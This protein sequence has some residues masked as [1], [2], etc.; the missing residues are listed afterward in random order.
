[1]T[2]QVSIND[3]RARY[4]VTNPA[5]QNVFD[6]DFPLSGVTSIQVFKSGVL[7]DAADYTVDLEAL[8]VT[9][10]VAAVQGV[11]VTLEGLRDLRRINGFPLRGG[12]ESSRI[13][14][15][16]NAVYQSLQEMRRD[17]DRTIIFNKAEADG[18]SNQLPVF[19]ANKALV[20]NPAGDGITLSEAN[21]G[22]LDAIIG[23]VTAARDA[24]VAAQGGAETAETG[25]E[26]AQAAAETARDL[27]QAAVG[28]VRVSGDDL[29]ADNLEAKL[30]AGDGI[31]LSTQNSGGNETRRIDLDIGGLDPLAVP[32]GTE[33]TLVKDVND[34]NALKE[35]ALQ[36]IADLSKAGLLELSVQTVS[37]PVASVD[38]TGLPSTYADFFIIGWDI[39]FAND[40]DDLEARLGNGEAFDSG[41]AD[42]NSSLTDIRISDSVE[43]TSSNLGTDSIE[44]TT[45]GIGNETYEGIHSLFVHLSGSQNAAVETLLKGYMMWRTATDASYQTEFRGERQERAVHDR[46]QFFASTGNITGGSFALC[47]Y[48]GGS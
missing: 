36:A 4:V 10:D 25:S 18:V 9:L 48:K 20:V 3:R 26:T 24:A 39:T 29:A 35:V 2:D 11:I 15:D 19:S 32:D 1:M 28:G 42:Y 21:I 30:L 40:G 27:A 34:G 23:G 41:G 6:I 38:F 5:G 14:D 22:D 47:V 44:L 13:N 45:G 46:I 12:L 31:T 43:A 16:M 17:V 37:T 8:T 7:M 33:T